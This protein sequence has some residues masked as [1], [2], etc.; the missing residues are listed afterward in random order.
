MKSKKMLPMALTIMLI[1]SFIALI[2]ASAMECCAVCTW[3]KEARDY[4]DNYLK[5]FIYTLYTM[6]GMPNDDITVHY[7][8]VDWVEGLD[9]YQATVD[10]EVNYTDCYDYWIYVL[11]VLYGETVPDA[12]ALI[13][14]C[15]AACSWP[16]TPAW[17]DR[18]ALEIS[19]EDYC[20][21][22]EDNITCTSF[23]VS[24]IV[25]DVTDMWICGI[26][27]GYNASL[28]EAV[29]VYPGAVC[30]DKGVEKWLPTDAYGVFHF[31]DD[32]TINN[33]RTYMYQGFL[34]MQYVWVSAFLQKPNYFT[35][36]GEVFKIEFH[37]KK[38]PP[39]DLV[40]DPENK[41]LCCD[42]DLWDTEVR[43][44][45]ADWIEHG[46]LDGK[47]CYIRPQK[48]VGTPTAVCKVTPSTVYVGDSVTF[49]GTGSDDGGAGPL[50]YD[51]D[52]GSDGSVDASGA[53][54]VWPNPA[55]GDFNVTL[56]VTNT[57][58]LSDT[59]TCYW[60]VKEKL[61]PVID[62]YTSTN[63]WCGVDTEEGMVGKGDDQPCDALSPDV[64]V[65]FYAEVTYN[66]A[67]VNHVFVAF[68]ILW[69]WQVD[70][71]HQDTPWVLQNSCVLYATAETNKDGIAQISFRVPTSCDNTE[72]IGKWFAMAKCKVQQVPIED[73][74][75]FDVGYLIMMYDIEVLKEVAEDDWQPWTGPFVREEDCLGVMVYI[76]SIAWIPRFAK[77]ILVAY[78][79]C[80]VPLGQVIVGF[81]VPP[82]EGYCSPMHG[83][84]FIY[85]LCIPQYAYVGMGR[86][87]VSVFT[88]L[89]HNCGVPYS[90]GISTGIEI[91]WSGA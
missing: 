59:D 83:F 79:E 64:N 86:I 17:P 26:K 61:G 54:V 89:P 52:V 81:P 80:N 29:R 19:Q 4:R 68:E 70:W 16:P 46:P 42:L 12:M 25:Q 88:E 60:T 55:A 57:L 47:Y 13:A 11:T 62:L 67:P 74:M 2:P 77:F 41:C 75:R 20:F 38:A 9:D 56:N 8:W 51:W 7:S 24:V 30:L 6:A 43:D 91:T 44:S 5:C 14:A 82:A 63:R 90:K 40:T 23:N 15:E 48:V 58:G 28:I 45:M 33:T 37:I 87:E 22:T 3:T 49:D 36:T 35:G 84:V 71:Y 27:L 65:T 50:T 53:T 1:L 73:T 66:G 78:D 85:D 32:P 69:E 34:P 31:D 10:G 39:R 72:Y 76:K 21:F 18:T